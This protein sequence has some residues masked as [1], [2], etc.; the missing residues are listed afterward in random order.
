MK[1]YDILVLLNSTSKKNEK[2]SILK[3]NRGNK[4]FVK[5]LKHTYDTLNINYYVKKLMKPDMVGGEIIDDNMDVIDSL[6]HDLSSRKITGNDALYG[7]QNVMN[8]F[9][10]ESQDIIEKI[11][12]RDLKCGFSVSSINKA[13]PDL[14]ETFDVALAQSYKDHE[15]KV[16]GVED[17]Y[18]S[19]K[20][21]G[22]RCICKK[23]M[24]I[25]TFWSR[26]GNQF[27]TL[28]NLIPDLEK[29]TKGIDNIVFDGEVCIMNGDL[30]DFT[31]ISSEYNRKNHTIKHPKYK[32]FDALTLAEFESKTSTRKFSLRYKHLKELV[33]S[34]PYKTLDVLEQTK[35]TLS[36]F[37]KMRK[38]AEEKGWE[39]LILR[40]DTIYNGKRSTDI[41]KVK[42]FRDEECFITDIKTGDYT[43]T[44]KGKGQITEPMMLKAYIN[45]EGELVEGTHVVGVGSGWSIEQRKDFYKHP[46]KIIGKQ[47]TVKYF[48]R[49]LN[50]HGGESMRFPTVKKIW[51][52]VR[53]V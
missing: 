41:L 28:D 42:T 23:V 40:K 39:G 29:L 32:M 19:R 1:V 52:K 9:T 5:V 14:I 8:M 16:W 36:L 46:E 26:Q 18:A 24:G 38:E 27:F 33:G 53:D 30:E 12:N 45:I 13:I 4:A 37:N 17:W 20:L 22:L 25:I 44:L 34:E 31:A 35:I 50:K 21:D 47:I 2:I 7:V 49:S 6:L 48:G 15:K 51:K 10:K 43:H 3:A 11:I